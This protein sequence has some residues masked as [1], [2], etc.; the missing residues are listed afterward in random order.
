MIRTSIYVWALLEEFVLEPKKKKINNADHLRRRKL[1]IFG[2]YSSKAEGLSLV[3]N[4]V[5]QIS[6]LDG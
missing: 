6:A 2:G 4:V 3:S 1:S 5:E